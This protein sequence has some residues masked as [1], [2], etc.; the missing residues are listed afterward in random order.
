[1]P[2]RP[3]VRWFRLFFSAWWLVAGLAAAAPAPGGGVAFQNTVS[4]LVGGSMSLAEDAA[5]FIWVGTQSGLVRW[6]GFLGRSYPVDPARPDALPDSFIRT[7]Y[8]DTAGRL[9]V[10][11]N[12]GGLARYE[13]R[14]ETFVRIADPQG[15]VGNEVRTLAER[16][17][18]SLWVGGNRGLAWLDVGS[19]RL[20]GEAVP[21]GL[22]SVRAVHAGRDGALW[23]AGDGGLWRRGAGQA[24]FTPISLPT[25]EGAA[26]RVTKLLEDSQ[27]RLWVGTRLSGVYAVE[28]GGAVGR[29][30]RE[31]GGSDAS[32]DTVREI[33]EARPGEIW[34]GTYGDGVLVLD[35][36]SGQTRRERHEAARASSL[37][38]DSVGAMLRARN[39]LIWV[40]TNFA[41]SRHDPRQDLT[42]ALYGGPGHA[43]RSANVPAVLGLRDGRI[44]MATGEYGAQILDRERDKVT[45]LLADPARP[46]TA[47][48]KARVIALAQGRGD[49]VWIG[50]QGG[51]YRARSD[52]SRLARVR[53][54][55]MPPSSEIWALVLRQDRLWV[56]GQDGVWEVDLSRPDAPR[57]LRHLEV[58]GHVQV[59]ALA[60]AAGVLWVGTN[61]GLAR[62]AED[63]S[64]VAMLP[65]EPGDPSALP[66]GMVAG[67]AVD[68]QGRLWVG[69]FG[70]G[71]QVASGQRPD[72][73][74]AFRRITTAE[75]LPH[76]GVDAVVV[77]GEGMLWAST[78]DGLARID[79]ATLEVRSFRAAQNV[80][81]T[82]FWT[83]AGSAL[84]NGEL[85]FGGQGGLLIVHPERVREALP[86]P[87]PV[88]TE[89]RLGGRTVPAAMLLEEG[90]A[91]IPAASRSLMVEFTSLAFTDADTLRYAYRL[92]GFDADWVETPA[93]R[94]LASYTNLPPGRY[95]LELRVAPQRGAWSAP[96]AIPVQVE[97]LWYQRRGVQALGGLLLLLLLVGAER[98]RSLMLRRRQA[99]LEALVAQRTEELRE[100]QAQLE[101]MA[102]FDGLTGL[103]NRRLFNEELRGRIAE[104]RRGGGGFALALIDL[105]RF[106]QINDEYGHAAGD[107]MLVAAAQRLRDVVRAGDRVARLGGDEFVALLRPVGDSLEALD[108]VCSRIV[109]ELG[110][111]LSLPGGQVVQAGASVG[112][113]RCPQAA[114]DADALLKA[115]DVALYEAKHAG[116]GQWRLWQPPTTPASLIPAG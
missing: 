70:R 40:V 48:P 50:T 110:R 106:K 90:G 66:G 64:E 8:V 67:L 75:G 54:P 30:V 3:F 101:K 5:G 85:L 47:L 115:A 98:L 22:G 84:P 78:D 89:A 65:V 29:P 93:Q 116:R 11:T 58:P 42:E 74:P 111:P 82:M 104:V 103:A 114:E 12:V 99:R 55:G 77:D 86:P 16:A 87:R 83:G 105:D 71:L 32:S 52:G 35:V 62:L 51:L 68:R 13:P 34:I 31:S 76:N 107:A 24:E 72:G 95:V 112:V 53:L 92:A 97:A 94:Q 81:I 61:E 41:L 44:W 57:A 19:G 46:D 20:Q 59:T 100:S 63:A 21:A 26:P 10:G 79:P 38:D 49:E 56:G 91:V 39:G 7:L 9:W 113:A 28:A 17:P 108:A 43:V 15:L 6:D 1:M 27:G 109:E 88:V 23:L 60:W 4:T 25:R 2:V 80:G 36:A 96:L 69:T 33:V 14:T 45:E 18:G 102:Y 73:T 37:V